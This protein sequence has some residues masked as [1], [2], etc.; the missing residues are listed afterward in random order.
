MKSVK[1]L[2]VYKLAFK[3]TVDIYGITEKFPQ[4]EQFGLVSQ[5]R[6]AAVSICSN[7]AEG[8]SRV[9]KCDYRHFV[10]IARGSAAE[11][12]CQLD[13]AVALGFVK[14]DIAHKI[15]ENI[16]EVLKMLSG[17]LSSLTR[18]TNTNHLIRPGAK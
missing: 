11:L 14:A 9:S 1:D 10:G 2:N 3:L 12:E 15:Q 13:L 18:T 5:M 16:T 7:L 6:R 4:V 8:A 17:L